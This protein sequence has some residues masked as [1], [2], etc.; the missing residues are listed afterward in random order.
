MAILIY[1]VG[2]NPAGNDPMMQQD[3]VG[4]DVSGHGA[5]ESVPTE[6]TEVD[7]GPPEGPGQMVSDTKQDM[8]EVTEDEIK[9]ENMVM[10]YKAAPNPELLWQIMM[11]PLPTIG[12]IYEWQS[13]KSEE[14]ENQGQTDLAESSSVSNIFSILPGILNSYDPEAH[15]VKGA[16]A[17][18][19]VPKTIN[20]RTKPENRMGKIDP[21]I[22]AVLF[23]GSDPEL[24]PYHIM[25]N[26]EIDD[27]IDQ[28]QQAYKFRDIDFGRQN[29]LE[30][31]VSHWNKAYEQAAARIN[32]D[33]YLN[34]ALSIENPALY[35]ATVPPRKVTIKNVMSPYL[36]RSNFDG[37]KSLFDFIVSKA[38]EGDQNFAQLAEE[39]GINQ[40]T[41]FEMPSRSPQKGEQPGYQGQYFLNP[42]MLSVFRSYLSGP[43]IVEKMNKMTSGKAVSPTS[44]EGEDYDISEE[45]RRMQAPAEFAYRAPGKRKYKGR[46]MPVSIPGRDDAFSTAA[47]ADSLIAEIKG[48]EQA[49]ASEADPTNKSKL[50]NKL[51]NQTVELE[52][53]IARTP[54]SKIWQ[55]SGGDLDIFDQKLQDLKALSDTYLSKGVG[56]YSPAMEALYNLSQRKWSADQFG[57]I[58][59]E[60]AKQ[61]VSNPAL[62]RKTFTDFWNKL[63]KGN[64]AR[65]DQRVENRPVF[66]PEDFNTQGAGKFS[67]KSQKSK[68]KQKLLYL[69][70]DALADML[71]ILVN[72]TPAFEREYQKVMSS[73]SMAK[74]GETAANRVRRFLLKSAFINNMDTVG[75]ESMIGD[76][77]GDDLRSFVARLHVMG[78]SK[79]EI[80]AALLSRFPKRREAAIESSFNPMYFDVRSKVDGY[81]SGAKP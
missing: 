12:S 28:I 80:R 81:L 25:N 66:D 45:D 53:H 58:K 18:R 14:M 20:M 10:Q 64:E 21:F 72:N 55:R 56:E 6:E 60:I 62:N 2:K 57:D 69:G 43:K 31:A 26:P 46:P 29:R 35:R 76:L 49:I 48:T 44:R 4:Q 75:L 42:Q 33:P 9:F 17:S 40:N 70:H 38:R 30:E 32:Q 3:P 67:L 11:A 78:K 74:P 22:R 54:L 13:K 71:D 24:I 5:L 16:G 52:N 50:E 63:E 15:P 23:P 65:L 1:A 73:K 7:P 39:I 37:Q 77:F 36:A 34:N 8:P 41:M 59:S 61:M 51:N 47:R 19:Y 68:N 79:E 27:P